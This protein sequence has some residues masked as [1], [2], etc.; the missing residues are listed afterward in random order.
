MSGAD[1]FGPPP[2]RRPAR[3]LMRAIDTG[4]FPDGRD[5]AHFTCRKCQHDTGW[6]YATR[7]EA[8]HG[9]PCPKCNS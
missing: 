6:V 4:S 3:V 2:A 1:L 9:I 8:R 7:T 5:A